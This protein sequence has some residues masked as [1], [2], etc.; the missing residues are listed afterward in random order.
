MSYNIV[1]T[2]GNDTL[3]LRGEAGPGTVVGLA[4]SD[5]I[6]GGT[7]AA[8]ISGESGND[9]VVLLHTDNSGTIDGGIQNDS[10]FADGAVGSLL[11]LGG[12]G[13]DSINMGNATAPQTILG[14]NDAADD[15]DTIT[16]GK[17][18]DLIFGNGGNDTLSAVS[19]HD[20][21]IGGFGSDSV[22]TAGGPFADLVFG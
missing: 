2:S 4:G 3:N 9:T 1:G 8:S 21:L 14:G 18:N 11:L 17:G 13:R 7:G 20:T 16:G 19:G 6:F 5:C 12:D 10:I 15:A 22:Y